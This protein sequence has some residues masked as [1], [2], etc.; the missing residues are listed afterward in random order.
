MSRGSVYRRGTTWTAHVTWVDA[1]GERRQ[2]KQGGYRIER[3]AN[4][5]LTEMLRLIDLGSAVPPDQLTVAGYFDEW[6]DHL[7]DVV[8][9]KPST[10]AS[11][12]QY[13]KY[14][15]PIADMRLQKVTATDVDRIYR[16]MARRGLKPR[17]IRQLYTIARKA[18]GDAVRQGIVSTNVIERT[19]PPSTTSAKAPTF[20]TWTW[21]QLGRFLDHVDGVDHG[22]PIVFAALTRCRRGEVCGLRWS[23]VDVEARTLTI[24]RTVV[25]VNGELVEGT[26]KSHRTRPI[27]LDDHLGSMFRRHRVAQNEWRLQVGRHWVD[28]GLVF[29][30]PDGDYLKPGTLSQRFERLVAEAGVP[31]IRFH[32]LR[33]THASL[34][35]ASGRDPKLVSER[36]G[37]ATVAFTLDRYVHASTDDQIDAAN[38]F[39]SR[40][41]R[42]AR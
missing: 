10:I 1:H 28:Q 31:R 40:L 39:A 2:R 5:A 8:G 38:E 12:R 33:H 15:E 24:A 20:P 36:L 30:G 13:A 11:Y 42:V 4:T 23:D 7:A 9:R 19:S 25:D 21:E 32:D 17:T 14:L 34:L 29:P 41:G 35:V 26:P 27:G 16:D 6:L 3:E 37:H 22:E 18:F